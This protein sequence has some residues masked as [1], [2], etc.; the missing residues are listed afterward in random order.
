MAIYLFNTLNRRKEE[1][2]PVSSGKVGM[3]VCG[4]TVYNYFHIGNARPFIVFDVFR[5]YFEFKGFDVTYVENFTDVDD[6]IINRARELGV[7][8]N[9]VAE[10][11]IK[12]YFEDADALGIKRASVYP[13][14]TEHIGEIVNLIQVLMDKGFAYVVDGDVYYDVMKFDGYGRLSGQS[15]EQLQSGARIEVDTRKKSPLDFALWK[16]TKEGEPFWDSPW[17]RGRPGWHIECSAMSMKYLGVPFDIHC[18]GSDLIFPHHENEIAQSEA[19]TGRKFVNYWL[20]NAYL[21]I[22][23]EK[24]SKS[25]GNFLTAREALKRYR[26]MAIRLFMLSAHYRS[27][28]NF[29]DEL[30]RSVESSLQRLQN[31]FYNIEDMLSRDIMVEPRSKE[32]FTSL[33]LADTLLNEFSSAMD[34]DFNTPKAVAAVFSTI[35]ELGPYLS[36]NPKKTVLQKLREALLSVNTVL[37]IFEEKSKSK[38]LDVQEIERLIREREEARKNK[39]WEVADEI[40]ERLREM[41]VVLEDTKFGTRWKVV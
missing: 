8:T 2:I 9:E 24:M 6:K 26:P 14:A 34:D 41:G 18:G 29:S 25:L 19:A 30:L 32:D 23:Q 5:R 39:N 38:D 36:S 40:R 1:F 11:Y 35:R 31:F 10:R 4:P 7:S 16:A 20:H 15:I 27:P 37:G 22:D 21:L 28:I 13:R 3:Y 12:A 33:E 17:G